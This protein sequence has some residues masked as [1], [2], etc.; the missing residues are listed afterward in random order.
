MGWFNDLYHWGKSALQGRKAQACFNYSYA[1]ISYSLRQV[2]AIPSTLSSVV[3]NPAARKI[4]QHVL[5]IA[6]EDLIP[7]IL[8]SQFLDSINQPLQQPNEEEQDFE[9]ASSQFALTTCIRLLSTLGQA[10]KLRK[11]IQFFARTTMVVVEAPN[12]LNQVQQR[13]HFD[14]CLEEKCTSLRFAQGA[15][16]DNISY[17]FTEAAIA[18][19]GYIPYIGDPLKMSLGVY[20]KGRYA[21]TVLM[22]EVCNRHHVTYLREHSELALSIGLNHYLL[23]WALAHSIHKF[24]GFSPSLY[25]NEV[26]QLSLILQMLIASHITLPK[27]SASSK[28]S[29]FDPVLMYQNTIGFC[30][31][32][33][34]LGLKIKI[35]RS[36]KEGPKRS[37]KEVINRL[38]IKRALYW[39]HRIETNKGFQLL[40]PRLLHDINHFKSDPIIKSNWKTFH[41]SIVYFLYQ[42]ELKSQSKLV[43]VTATLPKLSSIISNKIYG[44]PKVL[45]QA[46]LSLLQDPDFI[47][48]VRQAKI[49]LIEIETSYSTKQTLEGDWAMISLDRK[50]KEASHS[51]AKPPDGFFSDKKERNKPPAIDAEWEMIDPKAPTDFF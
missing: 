18:G 34:L 3:R 20:H 24:S 45:T 14:V 1:T 22:P 41:K 35:E 17:L 47:N 11:Q 7:L 49:Y 37:F 6:V 5:R 50:E 9:W 30:I 12:L 31:D 43:K 40:S 8:V 16:R 33:F 38:P 10:Y 23:T 28:R 44:T 26:A 42:I 32:T 51:P 21:L 4:T 48:Y 39:S 36:M 29:G 46:A 15:L 25:Q 19:L 2:A 27:P 13:S